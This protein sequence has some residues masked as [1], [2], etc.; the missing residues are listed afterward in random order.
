MD[1]SASA[2]SPCPQF[3]VK[4]MEPPSVV[5][6]RARAAEEAVSHLTARDGDPAACA[7]DGHCDDC[8]RLSRDDVQLGREHVRVRLCLCVYVS[9]LQTQYCH[10]DYYG[11]NVGHAG[12][13]LT[14]QEC[15]DLCTKTKGCDFAV[16]GSPAETPP[17]SC[18]FKSGLATKNRWGYRPGAT[19]CCPSTMVGGCPQVSLSASLPLCLFVAL[20]LCLSVSLPLVSVCLCLCASVSICYK[21]NTAAGPP[22]EEGPAVDGEPVPGA[23]KEPDGAD[24]HRRTQAAPHG[25]HKPL[26]S[27]LSLCLSASLPLC[28]SVS[29]SENLSYQYRLRSM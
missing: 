17:C 26:L 19:T 15:C 6:A 16:F 23:L 8:L 20:C 12:V 25:F 27:V 24:L 11:P 2:G 13:N 1:V 4:R 7:G 18:W 21:H 5:A 9:M 22:P 10:R 14:R 29:L 28:L 3:S